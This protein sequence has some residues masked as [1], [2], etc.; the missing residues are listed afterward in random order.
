[1]DAGFIQKKAGRRERRDVT[2]PGPPRQEQIQ[3]VQR[4]GQLSFGQFFGQAPRNLFATSLNRRIEL[5]PSRIS[6]SL[7][8]VNP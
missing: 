7:F 5:N 1:M 8:N 4:F 6:R 2:S 3:S